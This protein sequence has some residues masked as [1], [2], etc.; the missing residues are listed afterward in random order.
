M[1]CRS[2]HNAT[3]MQTSDN[4]AVIPNGTM[5]DNCKTV[6]KTTREAI[7]SA[8]SNLLKCA[9][10]CL[11]E[12]KIIYYFTLIQEGSTDESTT[13]SISYKRISRVK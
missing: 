11:P 4:T 1:P 5:A 2:T 12:P 6:N 3:A 7:F 9:K 10:F 8:H 13:V